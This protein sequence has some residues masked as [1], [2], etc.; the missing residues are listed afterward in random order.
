MGKKQ[1]LYTKEQRKEKVK[2]LL[3]D[4]VRIKMGHI[5]TDEM[6]QLMSN[7]IETGQTVEHSYKLIRYNRTLEMRLDND[8]KKATYINLRLD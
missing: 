4:V 7:W 1:K 3:L 8:K 5:I 2:N 6:K